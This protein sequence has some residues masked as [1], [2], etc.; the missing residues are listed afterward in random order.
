MSGHRPIRFPSL[1]RPTRL[2]RL[3]RRARAALG[4]VAVVALLGVAALVGSGSD[5]ADVQT[6]TAAGR[7]TGDSS[8]SGSGGSMTKTDGDG[9][10]GGVAEAPSDELGAPATTIAPGGGGGEQA[11]DGS[12]GDVVATGSRDAS[13]PSA[14][15]V[16]P[17]IIRTGSV[18]LVV[19]KGTFGDAVNRLTTLAAGV[20][21]FVSASETTSLGDAPRGTITV[22]VP[23]KAFDRVVAALGRVGEVEASTTGS[24]DVTG[25]YTDVASHIRALEDEREQIRLVLGRA[26]NIPDILAVRDRLAAVQSELEQLQGRQQVLDDQTSLST[27]AITIREKG[28]VSEPPTRPVDRT[29]FARLWHDSTDRFTDGGR[30]IALGLATLAP[31]LLLALVLWLPARV[32]W[33]RWSV[34]PAGP[35]PASVTGA[36]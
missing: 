36:D 5:G 15:G 4:V 24:Q 1:P 33:R 20:G 13:A 14:P 6:S 30:S 35:A 34:P 21:G 11:Y 9:S 29:G 16:E 12:G 3:D 22:R 7:S 32:A 2:A 18:E 10:G 8:G 31:W 25:E 27:L 26:E 17:K 19:R 23:A 28:D